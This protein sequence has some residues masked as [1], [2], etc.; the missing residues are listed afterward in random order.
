MWG[1]IDPDNRAVYFTNRYGDIN[2]SD[3]KN[4]ALNITTALLGANPD[5]LT[6]EDDVNSR[7]IAAL[8]RGWK[9]RPINRLPYLNADTFI[10]SARKRK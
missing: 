7:K 2:I 5:E 8:L 4:L 10:V 3:C 6:V 9:L 1:V